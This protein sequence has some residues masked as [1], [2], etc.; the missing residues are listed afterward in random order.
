MSEQRLV[1]PRSGRVIGGVCAGI[2]QRYG[3]DPTI[4]R[5]VT[6]L[7]M[8]FIPGSQILI[9]PLLWLIIPGDENA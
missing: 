6:V 3:W 5:I 4:V 7:S 2:A 1:R 8:I 9:Y